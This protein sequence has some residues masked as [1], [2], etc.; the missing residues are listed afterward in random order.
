MQNPMGF[1]Q[2]PQAYGQQPQQPYQTNQ[3]LHQQPG[4]IPAQPPQQPMPTAQGMSGMSNGSGQFPMSSPYQPP[5]APNASIPTSAPFPAQST[6]VNG[7]VKTGP[8]QAAAVS[9]SQAQPQMLPVSASFP[10]Q[11]QAG[12]N[13]F[14]PP[15]PAFSGN[16]STAP[17][18]ST[19][20]PNQPQAQAFPGVQPPSAAPVP[21]QQQQQQQSFGGIPP[22]VAQSAQPSSLPKPSAAFPSMSQPPAPQFQQPQPGQQQAF[23]NPPIPQMQQSQPSAMPPGMVPPG[24]PTMGPG[25]M[26]SMQ[27]QQKMMPP[28]APGGGFPNGFPQPQAAGPQF[29]QPPGMAPPGPG[30]MPQMPQG[31][32]MGMAP[33]PAGPPMMGGPMQPMQMGGPM[34]QQPRQRL[35]PNMMP[36]AV[37]VMEDEEAT[38]TGLFPTGY[39]HADAPPLVSTSFFA[40][41]S[42]NCNPRLMRS[43]LYMAPQSN[44]MLKS[45]QLPFAVGVSPFARLHPN[46]TQPPLIDLGPAGPVR[47]QRCKAYM[48]PFMEFVEGGR[49]FRCPFCHA[50]T[51]VE[52]SYFAHLDHT[53][54]RTDLEYRPELCYG[55]YE[56]VATKQYCKNGVSPKEPAFIFMIDVSYN[57]FSSGM[58]SLLCANLER[59]LQRLPKEANAP[60]SA[61]HVGLATFDTSVQFY[62]LSSPQPKMLIVSDVSEMFVPIVDG[63]LLPLSK[64]APAIRAVLAEIPKLFSTNKNVET[65]V[66][67]TVQAGLDALKCADRSG[68]LLIFTSSLPTHEAPGKL[69]AREERALLGSDK[70]KQAL[71]PQCELYTKMGENCSGVTV[72]LFVFPNSFIDIS[73]IGQLSAVT[74]G[75]IYKY[76]YFKAEFDG[77]RFLTD[78]ARNVGQQIAFDCM[79]RIRTSAGIRPCLF[80][81]SFYMENSTDL[82]IAS[83]DEN[84]SFFTEIKHDDK[85]S[86]SN[87]VIQ[88]AILYTS[89]SGQRRLRILNL[90]LPVSNEFSMLYRLADPCT[91][92]AYLFKLAVQT[93]R[94]KSLKEACDQIGGRSAHI[95]ATYREKVS[96][97][98]P[99]G[100]LILPETLKLLPLYACSIVKNDAVAGGSELVVDEKAWLIELIRGLKIE[101]SLS[102]LYPK[103]Y[104]VSQLECQEPNELTALPNPI[105]CSM[106]FFDH[107]K[108]YLIDNGVALFLWIGLGVAEQWVKDVFGAE[109]VTFLNTETNVIPEKDNAKSRGLRRA[110]QLLPAS[111]RSR[112]LFIIKEKDAL[113]PWMRKFLVEDKSSPT[114]KSYV[115]YLCYVHQEIRN[116]L[117]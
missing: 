43:T 32:G 24:P 22:A 7:S 73:T 39:P 5:A 12:P 50:S 86:D 117:S 36:S 29:S 49:R 74:G 26:Q 11:S 113:E 112:K 107:S 20:Q 89:I 48:C 4:H 81:G 66:L 103:V 72:D 91:L 19:N 40:Q 14:D 17:Y 76:Q 80:S 90:C 57:A 23:G 62:D 37:Q 58:V 44:D 35:D 47:C 61:I 6:F 102:L 60:E 106:E 70:E 9:T 88:T 8:P 98:S 77:N 95:L 3:M 82:E 54:R 56:F 16:G 25:P 31:M 46:E 67:P 75:S 108:A 79:V 84:K 83:I 38:R 87:A 2:Q 69:K 105:R 109:S 71:T 13:Q 115:D 59:V 53:G 78:L 93:N 51:A 64:A 21:N 104:P 18:A 52:D 30:M 114:Q 65:I 111:I 96:E 92:F 15:K 94:E 1:P 10:A 34:P 45:S 100:Q 68:K 28:N 27:P 116:M 55:A 99:L 63:L 42:G 33:P 110:V 101:D 41:D 85:L 97:N